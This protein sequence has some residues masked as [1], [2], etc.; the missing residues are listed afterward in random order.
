MPDETLLTNNTG[1]HRYEIATGGQLAGFADYQ[2]EGGAV[3]FS[4]TEILPGNEGKGL[5][6]K[7]ARFALDDVRARG[8]KAIPVC[9]FIAGYLRKH[10]QDQ[11]LV[12][13]GISKA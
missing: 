2:L 1:L 12:R 7:L 9:E 10:P 8:L 11:D 13:D 3:R 5:A 6:S 4:H